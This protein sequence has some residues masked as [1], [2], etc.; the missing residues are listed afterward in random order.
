ML[1]IMN[2]KLRRTS[3]AQHLYKILLN[4]VVISKVKLWAD[5]HEDVMIH[6][7]ILPAIRKEECGKSI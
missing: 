3:V 6:W 5:K 1:K 7:R 2:K 4:R